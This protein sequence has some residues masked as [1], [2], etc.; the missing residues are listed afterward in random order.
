MPT[1][2]SDCPDPSGLVHFPLYLERPQGKRAGLNQC[3]LSLS[4]ENLFVRPTSFAKL[5]LMIWKEPRESQSEGSSSA[6]TIRRVNSGLLRRRAAQFAFLE[7]FLMLCKPPDRCDLY[8][9][10]SLRPRGPC[11]RFSSEGALCKNRLPDAG[12]NCVN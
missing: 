12:T 2:S 10:D 6:G 5:W 9:T 3:A 1:Q 11:L 8:C 4:R 7:N